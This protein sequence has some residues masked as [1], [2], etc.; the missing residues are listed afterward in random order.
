MIGSARKS[1]ITFIT[2]WLRR[3][4][5]RC[6]YYRHLGRVRMTI[7]GHSRHC[8]WVSVTWVSSRPSIDGGDLQT[9]APSSW[10]LL[11]FSHVT[12]QRRRQSQLS[13]SDC[14]ALQVSQWRTQHRTKFFYRERKC[15]D[16]IGTVLVPWAGYFQSLI[17]IHFQIKYT[18]TI[19]SNS[20]QKLLWFEIT[21]MLTAV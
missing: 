11:D 16:T 14:S 12:I 3:S 7:V 10:T 8:S 17:L 15:A 20:T 19:L 4:I 9:V 2:Y 21:K 1:E 6:G 5:W 18:E 13:Q